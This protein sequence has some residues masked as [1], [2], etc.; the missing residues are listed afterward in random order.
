MLKKSFLFFVI[1]SLLLTACAGSSGSHTTAS[2]SD[3]VPLIPDTE[4]DHP[5]E[6][7]SGR[8]A[9][10]FFKD[11]KIIAGWNLGN[12]LDS[13]SIGIGA[14]TVWGN[15]PVNQKLMNGIK[16]AG[17]DIIR[18]P[19]TWMGSIGLLPDYR[20]M[21]SRLKRVAE[22]VD[23]AHNAGLKVIITLFHDGAT[24][25]N[26]NDLGWLSIR[27]AASRDQNEYNQITAQ[28]ARVWKQIAVYFR[29]YGDWLIFEPFN[30]LHDGNWGGGNNPSQFIVLYKWSQLFVDTVRGTGANNEARYLMIG[31]Y[32]NDRKHLLSNGF[33]LPNDSVP[34]KLIVSFHYY[35]PYE[36]GIQGSRSSWGTSS[37]RQTVEKD[38]APFKE[39]FIEKNIQVVIGECGAVLQLYPDDPAKEAAARKSRADY[40]PY[41]F[42]TAKKYGLI[43]LYWDNGSV[44]GRGEKFG[45]FDRNNGQPNSPDSDNLIKLM[46]NAVK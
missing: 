38:F 29:N 16:D 19:V 17:F 37:D 18:I 7:V 12:T 6:P 31:A 30:E 15:P 5:Q 41:I 39:R 46:I 8:T 11:E 45:L 28:F 35:D 34:G 21:P 3:N 9:F 23:M 25:S 43:P 22:V 20:I 10:D 36:F 14:E 4:S 27:K 40:I 44:R 24:D 42:G 33:I 26:S 32:S 13:H 2:F 1:I